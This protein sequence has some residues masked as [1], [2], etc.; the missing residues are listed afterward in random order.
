VPAV[1]QLAPA[2]NLTRE[3]KRQHTARER[4]SVQRS[5]SGYTA[6]TKHCLTAFVAA[7]VV[8]VTVFVAA[9]VVFVARTVCSETLVEKNKMK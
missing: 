3:L 8:V 6:N 4:H 1:I 7:V 9:V 2:L 5:D